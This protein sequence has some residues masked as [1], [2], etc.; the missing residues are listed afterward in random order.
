M[1]RADTVEDGISNSSS[2]GLSAKTVSNIK[3]VLMSILR[4]ARKR[5]IIETV[6]EC[7][8]I[9]CVVPKIEVL[10]LVKQRALEEVLFSV[11]RPI[12]VISFLSLDTGRRVGEA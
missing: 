11:D 9:S 10:T 6:P 1:S 7:M 12:C 5:H 4:Y 3:L 8:T 2:T